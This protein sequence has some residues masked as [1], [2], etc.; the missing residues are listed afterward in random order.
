MPAEN[1]VATIDK[2]SSHHG[3]PRP[4]RKNSAELLPARFV[5]ARPMASVITRNATTI[6]QSI[7]SSVIRLSSE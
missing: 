5:T 3:I 4:D 7:P 6:V 1:V 2:P